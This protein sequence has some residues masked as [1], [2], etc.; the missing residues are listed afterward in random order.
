MK[1]SAKQ[2]A[3]STQTHTWLSVLKGKNSGWNYVHRGNITWRYRVAA[4]NDERSDFVHDEEIKGEQTNQNPCCPVH[5]NTDK[6]SSIN[7]IFTLSEVTV[8]QCQ[9]AAE[10]NIT[11]ISLK[12]AQ[13]RFFRG[14]FKSNGW[15]RKMS[16]W[17]GRK[18]RRVVLKY[19]LTFAR[20]FFFLSGCKHFYLTRNGYL[21]CYVI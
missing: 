19:N 16:L 17:L 13:M 12:Q 6:M 2:S 21:I 20:M 10:I 15:I 4:E 8:R 11:N 18:E 7:L 9:C 5:Q 1:D 3:Q 14:C